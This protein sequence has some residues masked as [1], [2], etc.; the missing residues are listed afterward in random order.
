MNWIR[1]DDNNKERKPKDQ[2]SVFRLL[3]LA[4]KPYQGAETDWHVIEKMYV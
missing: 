2:L 1:C 4:R 3:Y